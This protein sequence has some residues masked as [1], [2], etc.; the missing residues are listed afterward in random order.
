VAGA[1]ILYGMRLPEK[2][3]GIITFAVVAS[4]LGLVVLQASLLKSAAALKEQAFRQNVSAA[5]GAVVQKLEVGE[6]AATALGMFIPGNCGPVDSAFCLGDPLQSNS[7]FAIRIDGLSP[8]RI[9]SS[10]F[11]KVLGDT[12]C[13]NVTSPQNITIRTFRRDDSLPLTLVD[14]FRNPGMYRVQLPGNI[15]VGVIECIVGNDTTLAVNEGASGRLALADVAGRNKILLVERVISSLAQAEWQPIDKRVS[16]SHLDSLIAASLNEA[17]IELP[18]AF[19]V[20]SGASDSLEIT[21]HRELAG[22]LLRSDFCTA[23]F[24]NDIIAPPAELRLYFPEYKSFIRQQVQP[25]LLLTT[26]F[27]L[28]IVFC[29][30]YTL[31]TIT[32]QRRFA[33]RTVEFINNMTHEFK[34]PLSTISLACD[35]LLRPV[36]DSSGSEMSRYGRMIKDEN[37]RMQTQIDKILQMAV[38]EDRE[39][40]LTLRDVDVHAIIQRAVASSTVLVDKRGGRIFCSLAASRF[41]ILADAVHVTNIIHNLIENACKYSPDQPQVTVTTENCSG[42]I[43]ISVKDQG[44]G[45]PE[46]DRKLVFEKY[47]RVSSGDVQNV[48][49]FGIGLSYVKLMTEAMGGSVG[50]DSEIGGGTAVHLIFPVSG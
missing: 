16:Q 9:S 48:R 29:F 25:L 13:Y 42:G 12:L 30:A 39:Y 20:T 10:R 40:D 8:E 2:T 19:G 45:I 33:D 15:K 27:M 50:L 17:S 43:R 14:T 32:R 28:V 44:I 21:N 38:L 23:L 1:D 5:M 34:T 49:G 36:E 22:Q 41:V 37:L 7:K 4:L 35:A 6:T 3:V 24:P 11:L 18:Y 46:R 47:Y 31:R 26:L